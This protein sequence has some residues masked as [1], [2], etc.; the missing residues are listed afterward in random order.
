MASQPEFRCLLWTKQRSQHFNTQWTCIAGLPR[1]QTCRRYCGVPDNNMQEKP[2][3]EALLSL[4]GACCDSLSGTACFG[5]GR[6]RWCDTLPVLRGCPCVLPPYCA[7]K[8]VPSLLPLPPPTLL[9]PLSPLKPVVSSGAQ[10]ETER[11][12]RQ[13][14]V[15]RGTHTATEDTTVDPVSILSPLLRARVLFS[16][17]IYLTFSSTWGIQTSSKV[18]QKLLFP[19]F[20]LSKYTKWLVQN[21]FLGVCGPV[22]SLHGALDLSSGA[23]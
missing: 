19:L 21:H 12:C 18:K 13:Q 23:K 4:P 2:F 16:L 10:G 1:T 20:Y 7:C 14:V 5:S 17:H 22:F 3:P 11:I 8:S 6:P 9:L 15:R